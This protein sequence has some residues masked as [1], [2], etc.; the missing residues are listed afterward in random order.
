MPTGEPTE[1]AR[2]TFDAL[3]SGRARVIYPGVYRV[4][5]LPLAGR[6]ALRVGP[7]AVD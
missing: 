1:L 4:G 3:E 7:S 5:A 6:F 2:R